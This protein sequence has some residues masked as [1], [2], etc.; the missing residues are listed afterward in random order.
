MNK[1]KKE[2]SYEV[3]FLPISND[4]Q[5]KNSR[6]SYRYHASYKWFCAPLLVFILLL[7]V[8]RRDPVYSQFYRQ[9]SF[10]TE[11]YFPFYFPYTSVIIQKV[12]NVQPGE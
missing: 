9:T 2:T 10:H 3:S 11:R 7:P 8:A 4:I 6:V 12:Y 5:T 1:K